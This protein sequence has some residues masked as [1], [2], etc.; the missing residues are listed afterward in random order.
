MLCYVLLHVCEMA[1]LSLS[2]AKS[3]LLCYLEIMWKYVCSVS[4]P[5]R[6]DQAEVMGSPS[7]ESSKE[8][9]TVEHIYCRG[10]VTELLKYGPRDLHAAAAK[11]P[12]H[13]KVLILMVPGKQ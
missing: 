9:A 2:W 5:G 6:V 13:P 12:N 4:V 3:H 10:V 1:A 7:S 11:T 8:D